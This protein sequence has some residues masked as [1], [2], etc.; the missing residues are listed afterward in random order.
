MIVIAGGLS[1]K[2]IEDILS[3]CCSRGLKI[4]CSQSE[5]SMTITHEQHLSC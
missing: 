4:A 1:S 2:H 5:E 3:Q